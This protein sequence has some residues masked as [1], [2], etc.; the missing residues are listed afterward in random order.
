MPPGSPVVQEINIG[1]GRDAATL[2]CYIYRGSDW[3]QMAGSSADFF[4]MC[5]KYRA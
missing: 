4:P 2:G 1:E 3:G 5:L